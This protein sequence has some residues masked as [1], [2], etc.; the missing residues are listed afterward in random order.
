MVDNWNFVI[1]HRYVNMGVHYLKVPSTTFYNVKANNAYQAKLNHTVCGK[2]CISETTHGQ[3]Q[4]YRAFQIV[5]IQH[6][7]K[8]FISGSHN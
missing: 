5:Y 2:W 3:I 6:T 7:K 4:T 8:C 1:V